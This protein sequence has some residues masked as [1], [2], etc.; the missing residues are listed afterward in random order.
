MKFSDADYPGNTRRKR[1]SAYFRGNQRP[2]FGIE[3]HRSHNA[4]TV[5]WLL[6]YDRRTIV[7]LLVGI[8]MS[9]QPHRLRIFALTSVSAFL[10]IALA[11]LSPQP[12]YSWAQSTPRPTP[13]LRGTPTPVLR[14]T[15]ALLP[16]ATATAPAIASPT[17]T[18]VGEQYIINQTATSEQLPGI[19]LTVRYATLTSDQLILAVA[20][21]NQ[22]DE[23]IRF[24]FISAVT[25][26]RVQLIDGDGRTHAATSLDATWAAIQPDGGFVPGGANL[27]TVDFARPVGPGP[28]RLTGIFDYG[29]IEFTLNQPRAAAQSVAVPDGAYTVDTTLFSNDEV[30]EP[31][32]LQVQRVILTAADI[33]FGVAFVN[34]G[35]RH[36]GLRRGPTGMDATLLDADRRQSAPLAVSDSLADTVTPETGIAPGNAYT[37]TITFAR[38]AHLAEVR[39]IFTRYSPLTLRF[40]R[41]GLVTSALAT[42]STGVA[43]P[44]PTPAPDVALYQALADRL[45]QQ[46]AALRAQDM[47]RFLQGVSAETQPAVVDAF[48]NLASMPLATVEL[49]LAPGQEF[50]E[51]NPSTVRGLVVQLRYTFTG[52]PTDNLF[53]QDFTVDFTRA[54]LSDGSPN[55]QISAIAPQNNTPFWWT[56]AVVT[57]ES[58]HFLIFTRPDAAASIET[59][60]DEVEAAYAMVQAE[61]LALEARYIAYF[62]GANE[63]FAAYTGATNPDIL[64]VALSR[65]QIDANTIAVVSRAFYINGSNFIDEAQLEQRQ[66]TITHE[67]VHLALAADAR[68]YTPPWLSEGLAVYYAGQDT[69]ADRSTSYNAERLSTMDLAMLTSLSSLGVHEGA[70]EMTSYRYLYSGAVIEYLIERYGEAQVLA[71]YRS[72][73]GVPVADVQDRLPLYFNPEEQDRVFQELSVDVTTR[74]VTAHFD[75]TLAQ[76]DAAV[77]EWLL[78]N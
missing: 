34:T 69:A 17:S 52:T 65:Y 71:F 18:P 49:R 20:F 57:H 51:D 74:M 31:L 75:L 30:L 3:R 26:R 19:A 6:C 29:P 77:K 64:G 48:A 73:T 38:P 62:T 5:L 54:P 39:F 15:A 72:Y 42:T 23:A 24:S 2:N 33:T 37:G 46:S 60:V 1:K 7:L 59:L 44:T 8:A 12:L 22:S 41:N 76:L 9:V 50:A 45:A 40:D 25:Q 35:Y 4:Q 78:A 21:E 66:S 68:P 14:A 16:T 63:P 13:V 47:G 28:Y 61:G 70:G 36:Y 11:L 55:W 58:P 56:G 27:G 43:P 10:L 67:L 32:R 53:I